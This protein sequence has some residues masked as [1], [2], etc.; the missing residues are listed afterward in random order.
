M[1]ELKDILEDS[2]FKVSLSAEVYGG[3]TRAKIDDIIAAA[4]IELPL[5]NKVSFTI[6]DTTGTPRMF[7]CVWFPEHNFYAIK[8]MDL[9]I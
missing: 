2:D 1:A 5:Q 4:G 3:L 8:K 7:L 6:Y 9:K